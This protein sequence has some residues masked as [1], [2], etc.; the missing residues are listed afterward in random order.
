MQFVYLYV[1]GPENG[2]ELRHSIRSVYRHFE[3][4]APRITIVGERPSWYSGHHIEVPRAPQALPRRPRGPAAKLGANIDTANKITVCSQHPEID[5]TFIWMMDDQYLLRPTTV[6]DLLI[7]RYDPWWRP[8]V[9]RQWHRLIQATFHALKAHGKPN[10]QV[11]THLPHVFEK[12]KLCECFQLYNY[13][14]SLLLFEVLY[15][16]HWREGFIP[17]GNEFDGVQYPPFLR[18]LLKRP[19]SAGEMDTETAASNVLNYQSMCFCPVM[20]N[21]LGT[22][23]PEPTEVE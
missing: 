17:Y 18:Q 4:S 9:H 22:R 10:Y 2:Y 12:S 19:R 16:N 13:P 6:E 11:G 21:W 5:E 1:Q 23:F 7:P 20:R 3:G 8:R 14:R 15:G